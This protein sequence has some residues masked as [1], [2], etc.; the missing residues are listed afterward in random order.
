[1]TTELEEIGQILLRGEVPM[2]WLKIW[3]GPEIVTE[4]LKIFVKKLI[5]LQKWV[6]MAQRKQILSSKLDLAEVYRPEIFFNALK[7]KV[8]RDKKIPVDK[9]QIKCTFSDAKG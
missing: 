4:W 8:A 2:K 7:Q 5:N 9:L 3:E 1:M 6:E